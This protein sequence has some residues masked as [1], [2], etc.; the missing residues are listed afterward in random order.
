MATDFDSIYSETVKVVRKQFGSKM[1]CAPERIN[2]PSSL[3]AMWMVESDTYPER[4]YTTLAFDDLQRRSTIEIQTFS[5]K[6]TGAMSQAKDIMEVVE[7]E[8]RKHYYR[9]T[10]CS[11]VDNQSDSTIKRMVARFERIIGGGDPQ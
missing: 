4:R 11:P 8:L 1:L 2:A 5:N 6:P 10:Y 3:P 7:T 9:K